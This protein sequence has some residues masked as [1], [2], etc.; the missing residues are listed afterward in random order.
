MA[1][2]RTYKTHEEE[3][4]EK[5]TIL[6]KNMLVK[7]GGKYSVL[8]TSMSRGMGCPELRNQH[9]TREV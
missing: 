4:Q 7:S 1:A 3:S 9:G 5:A 8:S 2:P 6:N